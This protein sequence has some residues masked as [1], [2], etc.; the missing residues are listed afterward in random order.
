MKKIS[1][2]ILLLCLC[3]SLFAEW[4][5][6]AIVDDFGDPTDEGFVYTIEEGSFSNSAT[7]N[8]KSIIR[9]VSEFIIDPYPCERW[10]LEIHNYN[11]D[12]PV[13]DF[14]DDSRA[15]IKIKEED[16]S[17]VTFTKDNS[18]YIHAWNYL[19]AQ[20][21]YLFTKI[22]RRNNFVKVNVSIEGYKYNFV[23][24]CT[25]FSDVFDSYYNSLE[26]A[27]GK[28]QYKEL[29]NISFYK[30]LISRYASIGI[31]KEFPA[32]YYFYYDE[33]LS[34]SS[35]YLFYIKIDNEDYDINNYLSL[36]VNIKTLDKTTTPPTN[37][38]AIK[39]EEVKDVSI[40]VGNNSV[41][42]KMDTDSSYTWSAQQSLEDFVQAIKAGEKVSLRITT[43]NNQKISISL[44]KDFADVYE[45]AKS[46]SSIK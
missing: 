15:V 28:W 19:N 4:S 14:Y 22:L 16:G 42:M 44:N 32:G 2:M 13:D 37:G 18:K 1:T 36:D 6:G 21:G 31:E 26:P 30:S 7:S 41:T 10:V 43:K 9:I 46:I 29:E 5:I 17:V 39:S 35:N 34:T 8:S 27:I 12:N 24:D 45:K 3:F 23:I 33:L 38:T 40:I 20:D 25:D 11:W